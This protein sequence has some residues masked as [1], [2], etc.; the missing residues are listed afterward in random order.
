MDALTESYL[1]RPRVPLHAFLE[2]IT[3]FQYPGG[4][5][6]GDELR[7]QVDEGRRASDMNYPLQRVPP[8]VLVEYFDAIIGAFDHIDPDDHD[9]LHATV[10]V[11]FSKTAPLPCM[12]KVALASFSETYATERLPAI[13]DDYTWRSTFNDIDLTAATTVVSLPHT[14][15]HKSLRTSILAR[16]VQMVPPYALEDIPERPGFFLLLLPVTRHI[17]RAPTAEKAVLLPFI[18][19]IDGLS[20]M[21]IKSRHQEGTRTYVQG[22]TLCDGKVSGV[23]MDTYYNPNER[24]VKLR[25]GDTVQ[26]SCSISA[27]KEDHNLGCNLFTMRLDGMQEGED[28]YSERRVEQQSSSSRRVSAATRTVPTKWQAVFLGSTAQTMG[29]ERFWARELVYTAAQA[30]EDPTAPNYEYTEA[31]IHS[32]AYFRETSQYIRNRS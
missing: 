3:P 11:L 14:R 23:M 19:R 32:R 30:S 8:A 18:M 13:T 5:T 15:G 17:R 4:R 9:A 12:D 6:L 24:D 25:A 26:L 16:L 2:S 1:A 22:G 29:D 20:M 10:Q 21:V 7:A 31:E 28:V 27:T